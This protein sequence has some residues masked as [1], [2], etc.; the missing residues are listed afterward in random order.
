VNIDYGMSAL[1]NLGLAAILLVVAAVIVKSA[2]RNESSPTL[3]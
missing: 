1:L 3:T 2:A